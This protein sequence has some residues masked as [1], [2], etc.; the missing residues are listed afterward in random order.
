MT[1][2]ARKMF[3]A[4]RQLATTSNPEPV[5]VFD[6]NQQYVFNNEEKAKIIREY[7]LEQYCD[8]DEPDLDIFLGPPR[9]L[10]CPI[11]TDEVSAAASKL[12]NS[13]AI[14]PDGIPKSKRVPEA[15]HT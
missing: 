9:P 8:M 6:S 7:F 14:G 3:E 5:S 12:R 1:D 13:K 11:T 2:D 10:S 15:R 4:A